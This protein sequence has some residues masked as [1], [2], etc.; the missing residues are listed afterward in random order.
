MMPA[1][2]VSTITVIIPVLNRPASAAPVVA[3]ILK[4]Q[5]VPTDIVFV[6]SPDDNAQLDACL[7]T[8]QQTIITPWAGGKGDY[9]RKINLAA[10]STETPWVFTGADDLVF[11][12]GWDDIALAEPDAVVVGTLDLCNA[13]TRRGQHSTHSLVSR[14]YIEQG[15]IDAPGQ[16]YHEG[17]WHN[18]CDDEMIETATHRS[19][20]RPSSA[21]VQHMHPTRGLSPDDD[22]YRLGMLH[23]ND[24]RATFFHRRRLWRGI[25]RRRP[26]RRPRRD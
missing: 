21:V 10:A 14:A 8:G 17:Y 11:H 23:W 25:V 5:R 26:V 22:T 18:F 7:A 9:A 2:G 13:R 4:A 19:L 1:V 12:D 15:T 3:S 24:D 6:C 20:Y 16:V